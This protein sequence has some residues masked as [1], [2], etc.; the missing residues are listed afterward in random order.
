VDRV[1]KRHRLRRRV[2]ERSD[3]ATICVKADD[4][5]PKQMCPAGELA[6]GD[7]CPK[8][9]DTEVIMM[10][11]G[12]PVGAARFE[13]NERGARSVDRGGSRWTTAGQVGTCV[14]AFG[15]RVH[16]DASFTVDKAKAH[17]T[18]AQ[19]GSWE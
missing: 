8:G 16:Y 18:G 6:A 2:V 1:W 19:M 13:R 12:G 14:S 7:H 9:C 4:A 3:D 10:I 15:L 5:G 17:C 11:S